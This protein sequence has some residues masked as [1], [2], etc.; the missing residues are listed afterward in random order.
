MRVVVAGGGIAALEVLA[1]LRAL[2]GGRVDATLLAPDRSF[3]YRPLSMAAPFT[4]LDERTRPLE[5]IA[6]GLEA[7]YV[8]DGLA[9][10]DGAR[11]RVLTHDGDFLPY[12]VLVVAVGAHAAHRRDDLGWSRS[13]ESTAR[14]G[15]ILKEIESGAVR[16]LA[17]VVPPRAAWPLDAYELALVAALA[18]ARAGSGAKVSLFTAERT[19]LEAFGSHASGAI[20]AELRQ[21][22]I[23]L[24]AGVE[25]TL[26]EEAHEAGADAFS[27]MVARLSRRSRRRHA[28]RG[29][30]LRLGRGSSMAVDRALFLPSVYGPTISG[31]PRDARGFIPVDERGLAVG[32]N[33]IYAAGDATPLALKHSALSCAQGT[34]VAEAIAARAGADIEPRPWS[35]TLYGVL[36][37]P[38]HFPGTRGSPWLQSGEPI[39]HCLW[40]PPGH[41]AGCHLAP[42]LA[43]TDPRVRPG[44]DWH[45]NGIPLAIDVG[46]HRAENATAPTP[47][48]EP[49]IRRDALA[50]Q[51][52]ALRRVEHEGHVAERALEAR[53]RSFDRHEREVVQ[54]LRAAGY[55]RGSADAG[56]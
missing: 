4:F 30:V 40:W 8:R 33:R 10:I 18:A 5:D 7:S 56:R 29:L 46:D 38:P 35:P 50:R 16:S 34:A 19:P 39:T 6:A 45:P 17:L 21:A 3:S 1:G 37:L 54:Q 43:S 44:L 14:F 51:L 9:Q 32:E 26:P 42:F 49:D 52:I 27:S 41:A 47:P 13:A 31:I 55:L 11:G 28:T 23:E 15:R 12:D 36:T 48:A 22:G 20:A 53:G 25:A 2:A 24:V